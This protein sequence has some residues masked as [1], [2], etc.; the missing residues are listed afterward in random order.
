MTES[1]PALSGAASSAT[2][3]DLAR[4]HLLLSFPNLETSESGAE[5]VDRLVEGAIHHLLQGKP[6]STM[7]AVVEVV[8]AIKAM[9]GLQYESVEI[10]T[11]LERL[12]AAGH[13]E[14][15]HA[16]KRAFVLKESRYRVL[17][18]DHEYR[19]ERL[20][21]VRAEWFDDLRIRHQLD[22]RVLDDL[23]VGLD[24]FVAQ[25]MNSFAAEAASFLYQS[26]DGGEAR[27]AQI[28]EQNSPQ[29]SDFVRPE[30]LALARA[31]FPRFLDAKRAGRADYLAHRL[32]GAFIFHLLSIDP[33][34]SALMREN[35]AD[36]ILYLDTNFLFRLFGFHGPTLAYGPQTVVGISRELNCRLLVA[37]ETVHEFLR[38][39]RSELNQIQRMPVNH[40][41]YRRLIADHPG[42]E[43]SFMQA[44]YR[45]YL[46]GRV[47]TADEFERKYTNVE[48]I[49][50]DYGIEVDSDA[51]LTE[52]DETN[53]AFRDL[54]SAINS[55]TNSKRPPDSVAHDAFMLQLV[56]QARGRRDK[57]AGKVKVWFL[58]YDRTL[59]AFSV[60]R[61]KSDQL[62]ACLLASDWLQIARPFLPRTGNYDQS[63]VSMLRYPIA[64]EDPAVVPLEQMV[65]AL[66][67]LDRM[68]EVPTP[69]IAA[70]V[71]DRE[72][73][74]RIRKAK[75]DGEV[76]QLVEV[77]AAAYA[78]RL[79]TSVTRLEQDS[80]VL[81]ER[82]DQLAQTSEEHRK[83]SEV[84]GDLAAQ[85]TSERDAAVAALER[86]RREHDERIASVKQQIEAAAEEKLRRAVEDAVR[87]TE[88]QV[89][90][91]FRRVR[92]NVI[93]GAA[94]VSLLAI[95]AVIL[96]RV[97]DAR[98]PLGWLVT[99]TWVALGSYAL[100]VFAQRGRSG[101]TL[102]KSAD[103]SGIVSF[104]VLTLQT[105][106]L[107][108]GEHT[109][110]DQPVRD[111][112][113]PLTRDAT[114]P[115]ARS[116][117]ADTSAT[118][119]ITTDTTVPAAQVK[120][121]GTS[122]TIGDTAGRPTGTA[123]K[124]PSRPR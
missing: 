72:I 71:S 35:V 15:K 81:N 40:D 54:S 56:R 6:V 25:L 20:R 94:W 118:P 48:R 75:E 103:F 59:T 52:E 19:E 33:A 65:E 55:W 1:T 73:V 7:L 82:V 58:T 107:L 14:F 4:R 102:S 108:R 38:S 104:L 49:L 16:E 97:P 23:W 78:K 34:A 110:S 46:G 98:T 13:V 37:E 91:D 63:F 101:D 124:P 112:V 83:R 27:F 86:S 39:L 21:T 30:N 42:D 111:S 77:E 2:K 51:E 24:A 70:M 100:A 114:P 120:P 50:T 66:N 123:R 95:A 18:S 68:Q 87:N 64:F 109:R 17:C 121:V 22:Q 85:A 84:A 31:E 47:K 8:A 88:V 32:R 57:T 113:A 53:D 119:R 41:A 76:R 5:A 99:F 61:A 96:W 29:I 62:P 69:V 10:I 45:E 60:R 106:N 26:E 92:R 36:K 43:Y 117:V 115:R 28:V 79:E 9:A 74:R 90:Q 105:Y 93:C 44:Y 12:Q 80:K 11:A 3:Y 89:R 122:P 67:R 116:S